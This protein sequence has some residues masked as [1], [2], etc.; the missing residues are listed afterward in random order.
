MVIA[1]YIENATMPERFIS[2]FLLSILEKPKPPSQVRRTNGN[3]MLNLY[4][5]V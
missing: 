3:E 2:E 4:Q 1:L 5:Y